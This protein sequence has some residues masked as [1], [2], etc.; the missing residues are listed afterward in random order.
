MPLSG[1]GRPAGTRPNGPETLRSWRGLLALDALSR[2]TLPAALLAMLARRAVWK[3]GS[4]GTVG[5][6]GRSCKGFAGGVGKGE[7]RG[8]LLMERGRARICT[9]RG[10]VSRR[11]YMHACP[12]HPY[13]CQTQSGEIGLQGLLCVHA[14]ALLRR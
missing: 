1:L 6:K 4:F 13:D 2:S 14:A 3:L 10:T 9:T 11:A 7:R 12:L 5:L 8:R